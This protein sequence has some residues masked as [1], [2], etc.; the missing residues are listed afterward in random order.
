MGDFGSKLG[1]SEENAG[2]LFFKKGSPAFIKRFPAFS[3]LNHHFFHE[4][5]LSAN[6]SASR[7]KRDKFMV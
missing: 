6:F 5:R 7:C 4:K 3:L 2:N 1:F